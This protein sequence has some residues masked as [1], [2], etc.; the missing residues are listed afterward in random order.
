MNSLLDISAIAFSGLGGA[1]VEELIVFDANG[2]RDEI[3]TLRPTGGG[4][5]DARPGIS[6]GPDIG[7]YKS[8]FGTADAT[9]LTV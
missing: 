6:R 3:V 1:T 9:T 7:F 5:A 8:D 2:A 4:D